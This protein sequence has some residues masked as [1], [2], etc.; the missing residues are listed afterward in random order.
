MSAIFG[1]FLTFPQAKGPEVRLRVFGDEHYARYENANG[2]SVVYDQ[3]VG[4]FCYARLLANRFVSTKVSSDQ[5]PPSGIV[6]HLQ[7]S[8][9][10]RQ[11][12]A[13]ERRLLHVAPGIVNRIKVSVDIKHTYIGDLRVELNS[14]TGRRALLHARQGGAQDDLVQTFDSAS[15]GQLSNLIGQPAQGVWLLRVADLDRRDEGTLRKWS[16]EIETA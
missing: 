14:P 8:L 13:E 10:V 4:R 2:Y 16:L 11:A 15:P 9:S 1:E 3:V 7:E 6:R 5:T 12:K